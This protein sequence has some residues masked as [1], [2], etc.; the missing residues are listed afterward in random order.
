[1]A[2]YK[3]KDGNVL[4]DFAKTSWEFVTTLFESGQEIVG[5]LWNSGKNN[6]EGLPETGW[7]GALKTGGLGFMNIAEATAGIVGNLAGKGVELAQSAFGHAHNA[8]SNRG[9]EQERYTSRNVNYTPSTSTQT[10]N[11]TVQAPDVPNVKD[12]ESRSIG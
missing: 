4:Q 8:I 1:M 12:P 9:G 11:L 10:E 5:N 2:G 3:N 6:L 7:Q